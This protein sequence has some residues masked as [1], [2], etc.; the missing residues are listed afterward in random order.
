MALIQLDFFEKDTISELKTRMDAIELSAT[1]CRR[2][3]FAE[4]GELK[5]VVGD[6]VERLT[7]LERN[8][9]QG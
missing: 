5:K 6:I 3:Q 7:I 9:C 8:I 2:K 4:I 1:K